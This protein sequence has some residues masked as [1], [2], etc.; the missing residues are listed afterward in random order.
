MRE[1]LPSFTLPLRA[2]DREPEIRLRDALDAAYDSAGYD[3]TIDY[4]N[5][6]V[7]PLATDAAAWASS[8]LTKA[9]F[10]RVLA[11]RRHNEPRE[12]LSSVKKRLRRRSRDRADD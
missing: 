5:A 2:G 7:P 4:R 10:D 12:T 3:L 9:G 8:I 11:A 1:P 6:A